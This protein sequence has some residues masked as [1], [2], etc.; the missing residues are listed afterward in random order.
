MLREIEPGKWKKI[1]PDGFNVSGDLI[2]IHYFQ[3]GS[4]KVFDV[5]IKQGWSN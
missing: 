1:Y 3:N 5:K 4:G 2:S